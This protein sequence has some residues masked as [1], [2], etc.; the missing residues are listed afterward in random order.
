MFVVFFLIFLSFSSIQYFL[1]LLDCKVK[2]IFIVR[3]EIIFISS[4][5]M[6]IIKSFLVFEVP[7]TG[8]I[9]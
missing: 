5:R 6:K 2:I 4:G 1:P 9:R 8:G 7:G 3:I